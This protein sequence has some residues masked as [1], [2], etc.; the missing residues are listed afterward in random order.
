MLDVTYTRDQLLQQ[1]FILAMAVLLLVVLSGVGPFLV[2]SIP[3]T[4]S[5]FVQSMM[6]TALVIIVAAFVFGPRCIWLL[7]LASMLLAPSAGLSKT[8]A[9]VVAVSAFTTCA[10][11]FVAGRITSEEMTGVYN[12]R[13]VF[14]FSVAYALTP[15]SLL[16]WFCITSDSKL[17]LAIPAFGLLTTLVCFVSIIPRWLEKLKRNMPLP[18][19]RRWD[20]VEP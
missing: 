5:V 16:V 7:V 20:V 8:N 2:E 15:L 1:F 11:V 18:Q 14:L 12:R 9:T 6:G 13:T 19:S 17:Y 4:H 3:V 10:L